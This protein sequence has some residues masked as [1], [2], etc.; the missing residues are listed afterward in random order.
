MKIRPEN[1]KRLREN[2]GY[3][4]QSEL[5]QASKVSLRT[6][7]RIETVED[8]EPRKL[9][10]ERLAQALNCNEKE[11]M[12]EH[13]EGAPQWFSSKQEIEITH[14]ASIA[15]ELNTVRY[16]VSRQAQINLSALMFRIIAEMSLKQRRERAQQIREHIDAIRA[17]R[18]DA[19]GAN[20]AFINSIVHLDDALS[21]E[22]E[23]IE[24]NELK[25]MRRANDYI[26]FGVNPYA[27]DE[28]AEFLSDTLKALQI[29]DEAVLMW[30][31]SDLDRMGPAYEF[32][33][34][35][36]IDEYLNN[37][38]EAVFSVKCG[39]TKLAD[40]PASLRDPNLAFERAQWV[41]AR[42]TA[43]DHRAYREHE[44]LLDSID[45]SGI[46]PEGSS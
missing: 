41:K 16:G 9:T 15:L 34:S 39:R 40:I 33:S 44:E 26:D 10:V 29:N 31:T 2:A 42:L 4:S 11:L 45:I 22:I 38:R 6:I 1:L 5:S 14:N 28:I 27:S 3:H 35:V 7:S 37:D 23:A 17:Y 20:S 8:Y 24:N 19:E 30:E 21:D 12:E 25:G 18:S 36:L 43:E 13:K 46:I 32:E